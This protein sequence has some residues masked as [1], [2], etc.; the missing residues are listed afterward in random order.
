MYPRDISYTHKETSFKVACFLLMGDSG[1][2]Y[3]G[4]D[5]FKSKTSQANRGEHTSKEH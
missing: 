5:T 3:T 2:D 4:L 1:E